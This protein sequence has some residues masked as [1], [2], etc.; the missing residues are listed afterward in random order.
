[1]GAGDAGNYSVVATNSAG[2]TTSA[3]AV[4]TVNAAATA[5]AITTQPASQTVAPGAAASFSVTASGNPA[6][7]FQ[8]QKGGV[9]IVGATSATYAIA[10]VGAGDAGN[11]AVVATNSAGSTTS[12]T[13]VLTVSTAT[14]APTITPQPA[15]QTV[16]SGTAASFSVT[17]S[18]NPTPTYQWQKG[19][20]NIAGATSATYSIASVVAGDAGNYA[21]VATNSVGNAT[22]NSAA[23]TVSAT[24]TTPAPAPVSTTLLPIQAVVAGHDVALASAW[25][26]GTVQWQVSTDNGLNWQNLADSGTYSGATSGILEILKVTG[27]MNGYLYRCLSSGYA[28][29]STTLNV[30]QGYFTFPTAVGTDSSGYLYV[31]DASAQT[32]QKISSSGQVTLLAGSAGQ[33]GGADGTGSTARF[34]QPGA[35]ATA[36]DGTLGVAD[37]ANN[38]LRQVSTGGVVTTLAGLAGSAGSADGTG[39]AARFGAP[40]GIA[41]DAN[42]NYFVADSA[43]HTIRKITASG[44]VSTLAGSA[45]NPGTVDGTG[46]SARFNTPAGVTVDGAGNVYVSDSVNH[47]LR[48]ITATGTVS[49]VAGLAGSSGSQDG[50]GSAARFNHPGGLAM[51]STGELYLADTGNSTIRRISTTGA[52]TT[53]AGLAG[54]AGLMDGTGGSAWF[55]Q[56]EGLTLGSDGNLYVADTGNA[57]IRKVTLT[58][59][60]TTLTLNTGSSST[61]SSSSSAPANPSSP[62]PSTASSAGAGGGAVSPWFAGI[63]SLALLV[64]R[65]RREN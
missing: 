35:V 9:N 43:N 10:S 62:A 7:T 57:A 45:G 44:V 26:S 40:S 36:A 46:T 61:A 53:V 48:K 65:Y 2:S 8:W 3:T 5:P 34:N 33:A 29:S 18:G 16:A 56:P 39:T 42:G 15:S 20:V 59:I 41:R 23:L 31:S 58:G 51:G 54:I 52:V 38:V 12:A 28:S 60:V 30:V 27:T 19:G 63:I 50:T 17:A 21:V 32:I 6:P 47:T 14:T 1:M 49:T 25:S 11:Y 4:L 55:D 13:A 64:R 37:T 24:P 22:S